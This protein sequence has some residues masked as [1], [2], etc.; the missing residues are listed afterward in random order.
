MHTESMSSV[1]DSRAK[2]LA[3]LPLRTEE[4]G[5]T[6]TALDCGRILP[7]SFARYVPD[8]SS[9]RTQQGCLT[10]GL[11]E[12]SETWPKSGLMRS[13][14]CFRRRLWVHPTFGKG[15]SWLPTPTASDWKGSTGK[16]SRR[17][18]LVEF[19]AMLAGS[20]GLTI[21]PDPEF[22]EAVMGFPISWTELKDSETPSIQDVPSGSDAGLSNNKETNN[23]D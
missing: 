7:E 18:T 8:T 16:G 6:A 17:G 9:W 21:Y 15:F 22:Y 19:L 23:D 10:G 12:F 11:T 3:E 13:G 4:K 1:G 5:S 20:G 14:A 2:T